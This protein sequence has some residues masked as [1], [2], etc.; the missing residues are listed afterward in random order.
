MAEGCKFIQP[1]DNTYHFLCHSSVVNLPS[2]TEYTFGTM[3][4]PQSAPPRLCKLYASYIYVP[5]QLL[6]GS[7]RAAEHAL[8]R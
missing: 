6:Q 7:F 1:A 4:T 2:S 8:D 3:S 5:T